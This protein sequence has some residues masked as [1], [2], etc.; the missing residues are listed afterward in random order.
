MTATIH[1]SPFTFVPT[2]CMLCGAADSRPRYTIEKYKQ[3]ALHFVTCN[4]CGTVYQDPMPDG[5]AM[6]AFYHSQSFFNAKATADMLTG[7]RDYDAEEQTR[8]RNARKRLDEVERLFPPGR[9]LRILKVACGYGALVALARQRG[10]DAEGID[11]SAVMVDGARKRY[12]ID[13]I[14]ADFLAYD[15]GPRR[16]DVVLLYGAINNFPRPLDVAGKALQLLEPG[17][18]YIVN[19][20]WT[21][22]LPERLLRHRYWIYRPPIIGL[23]RRRAFESHHVQLGFQLYRSKYDVQYLTLDKLFGYLQS[24]PLV[25]LAQML[26][27]DRVG[28]T[29][30]VPG[31]ARVFLRK[32]E[33]G[34]ERVPG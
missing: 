17:G 2:D 9:T 6:Q 32:P 16:Y 19:H 1:T 31:Y 33:I 7:Y 4:R 10:H 14:Q 13:L 15:F 25:G 21:G 34:V 23:Y 26:R 8:Q 22:S 29:I 5:K 11:Y 28:C 12:G 30:P 3:G 20:V 27:I 24:R 18:F